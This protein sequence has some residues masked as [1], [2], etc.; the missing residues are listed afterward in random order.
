MDP[1]PA[2]L[3]KKCTHACA[4]DSQRSDGDRCQKWSK[5]TNHHPHD[6]DGQWDRMLNLMS[7]VDHVGVSGE[8]EQHASVSREDQS[9]I[10]EIQVPVEK[11]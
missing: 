4:T 5:A 7:T 10:T 11:N 3:V 2:K 8:H 1:P 6:G 9:N